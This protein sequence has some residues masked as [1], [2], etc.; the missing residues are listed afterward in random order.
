MS[1]HPVRPTRM[2]D[3]QRCA[4]C[5]YTLVAAGET[6]LPGRRVRCRGCGCWVFAAG[7][8]LKNPRRCCPYCGQV[9]RRFRGRCPA[10][11]GVLRVSLW[12]RFWNWVLHGPH[13]GTRLRYVPTRSVIASGMRPR[14]TV[15]SASFRILMRSVSAHGIISPLVVRPRGAAYEL[16]SGHRRLLAAHKLGLRE[17]PVIVRGVQAHEVEELRYL[18]N[19]ATEPWSAIDAAEALERL[20]LERSA[21]AQR[22]LL[23]ILEIDEDA[24]AQML[25]A[26]TLP[27]IVKDAVSLGVVSEEEA[28]RLAEIGDEEHILEALL[29]RRGRARAPMVE[30]SG[31]EGPRR[32]PVRQN[33]TE[34]LPA[35]AGQDAAGRGA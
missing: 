11:R 34:R 4:L 18:D 2:T 5:G 14:R 15:D 1:T 10:C 24:L 13:H 25:R 8:V 30:F 35:V 28:A 33:E 19:A 12:R 32:E 3:S 22:D 6:I 16:V 27:E 7:A 29:A 31:E 23:Q 26:L 20:C 21:Q 17:V 9:V